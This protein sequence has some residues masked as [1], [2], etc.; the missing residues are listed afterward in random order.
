[1][2]KIVD[3]TQAI[4]MKRYYQAPQKRIGLWGTLVLSNLMW[5]A[6]VAMLASTLFGISHLANTM[7]TS[8]WQEHCN[9]S[10]VKRLSEK[11]KKERDDRIARLIAY[12]SKKPLELVALGKAISSVLD[13]SPAKARDFF[14]Q[15]L[16]EAM[17]VQVNYGIPASA[18]MAQ[19]IYESGYGSSELA[20]KYHNYFGIKAFSNWDGPR[21]EAMPTKDS[22]RPTRADFRAYDNLKEGFRGY[23]QH[24]KDSGRYESA[25]YKTSGPDYVKAILRAGYCPDS[26]YYDNIMRIMRNHNLQALDQILQSSTETQILASK[27]DT[28]STSLADILSV[29]LSSPASQSPTTATP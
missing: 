13:S 5:V 15:A 11:E 16:P 8:Y 22:G 14:E 6:V 21:A 12:K 9:L 7:A 19:A 10:E 3:L 28:E 25:F 27:P 4:A 17:E 18:V 26:N 24:M 29:P 2:P 1:M 23:A 20:V